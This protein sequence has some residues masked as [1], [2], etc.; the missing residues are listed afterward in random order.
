[1][2]RLAMVGCEAVTV[3]L[4]VLFLRRM[5][6]PVT[7]VVAYLWHPLPL[8]EIANGGHVDALMV[9]LMLSGLWVALSGQA[10][11][12]AALIAFSALVKPYVAPVLA[13]IW[14]PW[15]LKMP[16]VV[17]AVIALCYLPYLSVGWGVFGYLT[18]G[19][20]AGRGD[21]RRQRSLAV[22]A[23]A[24]GV[25]RTSGRCRRLRRNGHAG[26][27]VCGAC[28]GSQHRSPHRLQSGRHQHAVTPYAAV[29]VA[30]LSLVLS[31]R[32]AVRCLVRFSADLGRFDHC[33]D[34]VGTARLGFLHSENGDKISS[35][36]GSVAGLGLGDLEKS[37]ATD[38]QSW[39]IAMSPSGEATRHAARASIR[40]AITSRS[41]PS[42]PRSRSVRRSASIWK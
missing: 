1:M 34:A 27:V 8:W 6:Q 26:P 13:G 3:A 23:M 30:E 24:T 31:G 33:P 2:M 9:A 16:L 36:R 38:R 11:R 22:R 17:I 12:G 14:R 19:Y 39:V 18:K 4:I 15:D 29:V 20:L 42:A 35:V 28:C 7:R 40:A 5:N 32:H 41:Q 25:W 21:Q 10:L 37:P